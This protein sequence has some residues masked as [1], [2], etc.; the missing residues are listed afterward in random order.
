MDFRALIASLAG[1]ASVAFMAYLYYRHNVFQRECRQREIFKTLETG[2]P[3]PDAEIARTTYVGA[4]GICTPLFAFLAAAVG[5]GFL[6]YYKGGGSNLLEMALIWVTCGTVAGIAVERCLAVLAK[7]PE[8]A[9][10]AP[11]PV[12]QAVESMSPNGQ[13]AEVETG[14]RTAE[15]QR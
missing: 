1:S 6:L 4:I 11:R 10:V 9:S 8:P 7:R 13:P 5:T 12:V 15:N 14:I 3:L 2:Q